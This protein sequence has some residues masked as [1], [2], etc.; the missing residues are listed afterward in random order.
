VWW[1]FAIALR[2][3]NARIILTIAFVIVLT[4][5]RWSGGSSAAI[6]SPA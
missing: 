6:R 2:W 3:V 1:R 4:P 5:F